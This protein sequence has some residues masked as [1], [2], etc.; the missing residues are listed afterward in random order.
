MKP[1]HSLQRALTRQILGIAAI[2]TVVGGLLSAGLAF[3]EAKEIQDSLLREVTALV[4]RNGLKPL[5]VSGQE[6]EG[7][8]IAL[9]IQGI[10][11]PTENGYF[12]LPADLENG[13]QTRSLKGENWR[14]LVTTKA[15]SGERFLVAQQ[16]E[17]RDDLALASALNVFLP[18]LALVLI[19]LLLIRW[20][21]IRQFQPLQPL[22]QRLRQQHGTQ[23]VS[24]ST[25]G[26]PSEISPFVNAINDLLAR[27]QRT[28]DKQQ[29]F[30]AD[31]A[32][33]LRTPVTA[34]SLLA[35]NI[36][37]APTETARRERRQQLKEGMARMQTLL[38]QLLDLARLQSEQQSPKHP[39]AL[40]DIVQQ[41][42]AELYPL[43]EAG[44]IDLGVTRLDAANVLDQDTRLRQLVR[45]AI[46]N[47]IRYS[48]S[49]GQ[50][51]IRVTTQNHQA[52]F[53]VEDQGSGIP[54]VEIKQV[55]QPFYRSQKN[56]QSGNGLGLS[57][58][59][60][61]AQ[62]LGGKIR[63]KNREEGG[64]LFTYTQPLTAPGS[65]E[66]NQ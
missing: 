45:N 33:E 13:L 20:M 1:E 16:T 49:G 28:L 11:P 18:I 52:V 48:P 46:D 27:I 64:L 51:N 39:A 47:A 22:V 44:G 63:L 43:A 6:T 14:I 42:I 62:R 2:L 26:L 35:E 24:L 37:N 54:E 55:F 21:I 57:I 3:M 8:E 50:V 40:H 58:S 12:S 31:A 56:T 7:E 59:Q 60:E 10:D 23:L 65:G 38:N 32:H 25:L 15:A 66:N 30:I 19:M 41:S 61:I 29:R 17:L 4:Q 36:E 5:A 53:Q 9:F 34:L